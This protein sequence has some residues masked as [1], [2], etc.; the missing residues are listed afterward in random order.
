MNMAT[1]NQLNVHDTYTS[2]YLKTADNA[3]FS[4]L[5]GMF[6][7]TGHILGHKTFNTFKIIEIIHY[8]LLE[9]SRTRIETNKRELQ[10]LDVLQD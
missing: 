10:N 7:K 2:L 8:I 6:T 1:L 9:H 5:H 3:F 4:N